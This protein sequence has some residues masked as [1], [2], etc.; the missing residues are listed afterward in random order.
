MANANTSKRDTEW[1]CSETIYF[2]HHVR[3][4]LLTRS[5]EYISLPIVLLFRFLLTSGPFPR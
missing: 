1:I 4:Q 5:K 2:E 3:I